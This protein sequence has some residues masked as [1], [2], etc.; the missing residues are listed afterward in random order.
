MNQGQEN[1]LTRKILHPNRCDRDRYEPIS[2]TDAYD[3]LRLKQCWSICVS[4]IE[5]HP[6]DTVLVLADLA[7]LS[8]DSP[9]ISGFAFPL[10]NQKQ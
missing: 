6:R 1:I 4:S 9:P 2:E 7:R 3:V 5:L 10:K 8:R